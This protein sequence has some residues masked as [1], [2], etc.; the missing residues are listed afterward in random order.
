MIQ[1]KKKGIIATPQK[2]A[3]LFN[4][5]I[6]NNEDIGD[7]S[8]RSHQW[9]G[10]CRIFQKFLALVTF[11]DVIMARKDCSESVKLRGRL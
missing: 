1:N 4:V 2:I 11:C 6:A 8:W 9:R 7:K 3:L 5:V 10:F